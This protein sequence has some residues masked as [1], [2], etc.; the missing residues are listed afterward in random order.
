M[1]QQITQLTEFRGGR[2]IR[3]GLSEGQIKD[4]YR[5]LAVLRY[6]KALTETEPSASGTLSVDEDSDADQQRV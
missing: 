6:F 3:Q 2:D 1:S 5:S 4:A